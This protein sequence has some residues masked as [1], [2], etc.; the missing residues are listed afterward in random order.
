MA[1]NHLSEQILQALSIDEK[2]PEILD[3]L[4][5]GETY[6]AIVQWLGRSPTAD[7][8]ALSPR[9]SQHSMVEGTEMD[10]GS[11]KFR[12]TTVTSDSN[13]LDHLFQLYFAWVHPVN[14]LFSEGH[15][16]DSYKRQSDS[17]CSTILVNAICAMACHLHS[18]SEADEVDF[19]QLGREFSD[20]ARASMDPDDMRLSTIQAFAVMFL[21]GCAR[22]EGSRSYSYL[23]LAT[24]SL[25]RVPYID[26]DGFQEV[27]RNSARGIWNLN[28]LGASIQPPLSRMLTCSVNGLNLLSRFLPLTLA[29]AHIKTS[30]N[31]KINPATM[32]NGTFT[33]ISMTSAPRGQAS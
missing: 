19:E 13:V 33:A 15:F 11:P 20:A 17:Y 23:K 1:K 9:E 21:V 32:Q 12:W 25:P 24:G 3:R 30:T 26:I 28:V 2:I 4:Q 22:G 8:E 7:S 29:M 27:L 6:E 5:H 14:T 10:L 18:S 31:P 16:T